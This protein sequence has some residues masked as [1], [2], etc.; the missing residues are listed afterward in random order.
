MA[1]SKDDEAD[2]EDQELLEAFEDVAAHVIKRSFNQEH[3]DKSLFSH[4]ASLEV[5]EKLWTYVSKLKFVS[6]FHAVQEKV[7]RY[8]NGNFC[9]I[10]NDRGA[11]NGSIGGQAQY[12]AYCK[13]TG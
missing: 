13:E 1:T 9:G 11:A 2:N 4:L 7:L 3:D 12:I 5:E 6:A 8:F 10:I